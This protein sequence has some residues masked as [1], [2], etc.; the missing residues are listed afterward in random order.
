VPLLSI[1]SLPPTAPQGD[2]QRHDR[3]HQRRR[4]RHRL[5][6]TTDHSCHEHVDV[7]AVDLAVFVH[8]CLGL[9][10]AVEQHVDKRIDV[11]AVDVTVEVHPL[12]AVD[13]RGGDV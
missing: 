9:E 6:A 4:F 12:G 11:E 10:G 1:A 2:H 5:H 13:P 3:E 7:E 8:I